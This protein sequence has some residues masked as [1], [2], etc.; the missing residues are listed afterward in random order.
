MTMMRASFCSTA[1]RTFWKNSPGDSSLGSTGWTMMVPSSIFSSRLSP[2]AAARGLDHEMGRQRGL[3][4]AGL[5]QHQGAG[6]AL[7]A[8]AEQRVELLQAAVQGPARHVAPVFRGHQARE[9]LHPAGLDL[10]VVEA[11]VER[12]P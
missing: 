3:A 10:V 8:A 5:A 7:D 6:A 1:W 12:A 9:D 2:I 4:G 11:A